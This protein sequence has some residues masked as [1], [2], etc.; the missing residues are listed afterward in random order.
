MI[1]VTQHLADCRKLRLAWLLWLALLL[2]VA[3]IA[4]NWH[5]HTH[6]AAEAA[7]QTGNK[8]LLQHAHCDLCLTAVGVVGGA[9]PP[10]AVAASFPR[11]GREAPQGELAAVLLAPAPPVYQSRAPPS[12]RS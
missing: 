5:L 2:P 8:P 1:R 11:V 9:A 4:A 10:S 7:G 12:L 3:Q 6:G